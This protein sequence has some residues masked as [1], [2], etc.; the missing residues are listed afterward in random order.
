MVAGRPRSAPLLLPI[1]ADDALPPLGG[2]AEMEKASTPREEDRNSA[3]TPRDEHAMVLF[4]LKAGV[5]WVMPLVGLA[6]KG[7]STKLSYSRE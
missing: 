7:G 1:D 2:A 4:G 6:P 3:A 5:Y